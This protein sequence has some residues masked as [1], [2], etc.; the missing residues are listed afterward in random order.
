MPEDVRQ[1]IDR[2]ILEEKASLFSGADWAKTESLDRL[3]I[4]E[5]IL[6][7]GP[8]GVSSSLPRS[9]ED[10]ITT[11]FP[12][13]SMMA[14]TWNRKLIQKVGRA[15][16]KEC[17]NLGIHI[18]LAPG[19]NIKRSPLCG[20]NFEYYSEDPFLAGEMGT[21]F[22]KGVQSQGVGTSLK[23]FTCNNQETDR[24]TISAE[25]DERPLR[26]IYLPAFER[27]VRRAEPWTVMC[28]YNKVN[29]TYCSENPRLLSDILRDEWRFDGFVVSDWGAVND[30]VKGLK[31]GLDLEMPGP[32]PDNEN[33]IIEAVESGELDEEVLD[34]A[35]AKILKIV[36]MAKELENRE[37]AVDAEGHHSLARKVA[38]EGIVLLMNENDILP[39]DREELDSVSVIGR[40]AEKP[41]FQGGGSSEVNASR[42]DVPLEEIESWTDDI[43]VKFAEG[44]STENG[45]DEKPIEEASEI[46]ESTD[47]AILFLSV[48]REIESEGFDRPHMKL[49]ENQ[50][51]L[52]EKVSEVQ[53]DIVVVLNNGS[54]V[55]I[56]S[57]VDDVS[58][59]L[60]AWLPG[61]AGAG[62]I[63][64]VL[65]GEVNPS[66]RLQETFPQKLSDNPSYLNFPGE[67]GEVRYSEGLFIG[68]RYYDEKGIE[69]QFPFGFGL[70]YTEF[71][72]REI[73]LDKEIMKD[74]EELKVSVKVK[75]IGDVGGKEVVQLYVRARDPKLTRPDKE[76]RG[77]KK[78]GLPPGGSETVTFTLGNRD[79]AYYDPEEGDRVVDTGDYEILIGSS[80]RDIHLEETV[81]LESTRER[82][83]SLDENDSLNRWLESDVGREVIEEQISR[84]FM[85]MVDDLDYWMKNLPL[86]KLPLFSYGF[87][88][89]DL[90]E[91]IVEKFKEQ[92]FGK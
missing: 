88:R 67:R 58:A 37:I 49:P 69:P 80:S 44:Y 46:A 70:S 35:L 73:E 55:D 34:E 11:C 9:E 90:I 28:T 31:A 47:V 29:G 42:V 18:L 36:F 87:V 50:I 85:E 76:L 81:R 21:A 10:G 26:E 32:S 2:M 86:K 33:D 83:I 25:V 6:S 66:G 68:Y 84:D 40:T 63:V 48:S 72:Y 74:R 51:K 57:W 27:V 12:T 17:Q 89:R 78:V 23:H 62:A 91:K 15:L 30:R 82:E 13:A 64:D 53:S 60:E 14:S 4:P 71:E 56:S 5:I 38:S 24:M 92:K 77:F 43:E 54:A 45:A 1:L 19:I 79:F 3:D 39:L 52:V 8:H 7:D 59:L 65:F 41:I 20:R 16:G 22:V 61:Q 75:N